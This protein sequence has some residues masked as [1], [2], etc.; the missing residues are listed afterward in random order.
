MN[1]MIRK[2]VFSAIAA[3]AIGSTAAL[4]GDISE[5]VT[6]TKDILPI[7]QE[8]CQNCHRPSGANLSGMVA[9]MSFMDYKETRPWAKAIAKA[10][11]T[12]DMPPWLATE[13]THDIFKNERVLS[14]DEIALISTWAKT[15]AKRGN[16]AD[17]PA[18]VE[19]EENEGWTIGEPDLIVDF[20]EPF[21]VEDDVQDLY[22]NI[23]IE[24]TKE[25][26]PEDRYIKGIQYK[27]T[28][29]VV[30]HI[31]GYASSPGAEDGD[32]VGRR[33]LGG[34]APGTDPNM[35]PAG[36]GILLEAGSTVTLQM[37]YHKEPGPGT[38]AWDSS[39]MALVFQDEEVTHPITIEPISYGPFE[40]PPH[41]NAWRVGARKTFEN[42][43]IMTSL[44][45]HMHL[46]GTAA[47]YIAHYPDGSTELLLDVPKYDFNWQTDYFYK[48]P[49]RLP[50][51]T[52]IEVE[53]HFDNSED[54]A[55]FTNI[56]P[57]RSVRFG[58]PTTDEMD[59][60]WMTYSEEEDD[61]EEAGD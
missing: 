45:P 1:E 15:G 60:M 30:H 22:Q 33:Q 24:L 55:S 47:K 56:N 3:L 19:W 38:G 12:R 53:M 13:A 9:P 16:P 31:I 27:P 37:H 49:K 7:L 36:Y 26:L 2:S 48:E 50:A 52:S 34:M 41:Q 17:A 42:P 18:P 58:G 8:N 51:G 54:R 14:E 5:P 32:G 61:G 43:I 6:F 59:L 20:P 23:S 25:M 39:Q 46:R 35:L 29:E 57:G 28:S 10:V 40:I 11:E 21:W 44:M 4:A